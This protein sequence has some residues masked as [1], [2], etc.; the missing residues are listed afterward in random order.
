MDLGLFLPQF[1]HCGILLLSLSYV[2]Y[3]MQDQTGS[4]GCLG[5]FSAHDSGLSGGHGQGVNPTRVTSIAYPRPSIPRPPF[6]YLKTFDE[7]PSFHSRQQGSTY[8]IPPPDLFCDYTSEVLLTT[9]DKFLCVSG[10]NE[11]AGA[12]PA[13]IGSPSEQRD[14]Q[15]SWRHTFR[16]TR[17]PKLFLVS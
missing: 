9:N 1:T 7:G 6:S 15:V 12:S 4:E 17:S 8:T 13:A 10:E 14:A 3:C 2:A 11:D 16:L 5:L